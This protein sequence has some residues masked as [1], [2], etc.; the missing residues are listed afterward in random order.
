MKLSDNRLLA[1]VDKTALDV[2]ATAFQPVHLK[3]GQEL[4]APMQPIEHLYFLTAG[5]SSDVVED[6]GIERIEVGCVGYEGFT[7]VPVVLGV[8]RTPHRSFMETDGSAFKI[9][10]ERLLEAVRSHSSFAALLHRYVHVYMIQV[11]ATALADGRYNVERRTARWLL[12]AHDR[13]R[14]DALPLTHDFLALMLGVRRAGVTNAVH[15]LEGKGAIKAT[16]SVITVRSRKTLEE[17]AGA[18]YGQPEAE[19]RRVFERQT[20]EVPT[21]LA[22]KTWEST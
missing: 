3:K 18:C 4:H 6:R 1:L 8:D 11:A 7:G 22:G 16:R 15:V 2:V 12:M 20:P 19:Y 9:P 5:L 13:M 14:E 21:A 17:I 10:T